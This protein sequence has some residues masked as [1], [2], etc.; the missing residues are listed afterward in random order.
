MRFWSDFSWTIGA[1]IGWFSDVL[2]VNVEMDSANLA[3]SHPIILFQPNCPLYSFDETVS[4]R[5][6][7]KSP[8]PYQV[9]HYGITASL[10]CSVSF[11][12]SFSNHDIPLQKIEIAEPAYISKEV[13]HH[14]YHRWCVVLSVL[15]L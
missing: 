13:R 3:N 6:K 12:E 7:I 8:E 14:V 4:G 2:E 1:G 10:D 9:W 5:I 15:V 11:F